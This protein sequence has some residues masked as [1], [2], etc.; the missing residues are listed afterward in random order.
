[1]TNPIG[2]PRPV[3]G[4]FRA[5]GCGI[6]ADASRLPEFRHITAKQRHLKIKNN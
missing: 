1:V 3:C 5:A 4:D 6:F 2:A